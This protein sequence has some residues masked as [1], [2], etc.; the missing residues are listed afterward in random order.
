MAQSAQ[1]TEIERLERAFWQSLVDRDAGTA[2]G[3]LAPQALMVSSHGTLRF[4]PAQYEKML[5]DPKHGLLEYTLSDM[6]VMFP[7]D[8]IAI[9]TY[10]AHQKMEMDGQSLEQD[11]VDS[12]TWVRVDGG[13]KCAAHTESESR[14]QTPR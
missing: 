9:A 1:R 7:S 14:G 8:D 3:L 11:V 2:K 5:L 13:W 10:R 6:D 12:S 4:D